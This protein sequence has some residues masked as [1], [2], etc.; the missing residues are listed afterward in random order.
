MTT[1]AANSAWP[2]RVCD[3]RRLTILRGLLEQPPLALLLG[4]AER[5]DPFA[6]EEARAA[7][8]HR[9][10]EDDLLWSAPELAAA[11]NP[12]EAWLIRALLADDNAWSRRIERGE[13]PG[14]YLSALVSADLELLCEAKSAVAELLAGGPPRSA[15]PWQSGSPP[16]PP[17]RVKERTALVRRLAAGDRWAEALPL[18]ASYIRVAGA[19]PFNGAAA[20]RWSG[21]E[22]RPLVPV[23]SPDPTRLEELIGYELPR[24][25]VLE[26]T[27]RMLQ[28]LPAHNLLL[29]GDRGTGKSATV[30]ALAHRYA[31]QGLRLVEVAK[32]H[33]TQIARIAGELGRRGLFFVLFVDDL[34]FESAET[35][36][37][38]LK[39][40]LEGSLERPESNVRV[41]ATSNRRHLISES[42]SD[43][44]GMPMGPASDEVRRQDTLQEKLSLA[45]RFGMTIIFASPSKAEYLEI[46][47]ELAKRRGLDLPAETL[48]REALRWADW[49]NGRSARTARQF[50]E[51]LVAE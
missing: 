32:S 37:K 50:V 34:S 49:Q 36:Y 7:L 6:S 29:Y 42:F 39:A 9:L 11:P 46:V 5:Q 19:G 26:N 44:T 3:L 48:E 51:G 8:L 47:R 28:G 13:E 38:E 15:G 40:A 22:G 43:R 14:E 23:F 16:F 24:R 18:L 41:Y 35:E 2:E 45:D 12:W 21:E 33:L 17:P 27:E 4:F 25:Q 10:S 31:D 1:I 30:K 20:F